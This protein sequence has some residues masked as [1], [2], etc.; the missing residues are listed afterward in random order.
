MLVVCSKALIVEEKWQHE[1]RRFDEDF[2]PLDGPA[3]R[4]CLK[5]TDLDGEWPDRY[6]RAIVPFSLFNEEFLLGDGE[7]PRRVKGLLELSPPP[8]FD[9]IIVDEAHNA[10]NPES[11][12]HR[13]LRVLCAEA[14][15]VLFLTATPIQLGSHELFYL[16]NLL[17]PDVIIDRPTFERMAEPN[18]YINMAISAAR[19]AGPGWSTTAAEALRKATDTPWGRSMLAPNPGVRSV[20]SRL[21]PVAPDRERVLLI[22]HMEELHTFSSLINRTRR[23]DIGE[24]TLRQA[25]T[26]SISF[27]SSQQTLHDEGLRLQERLLRLRYGDVP[28]TFLT[29]TIRRQLASCVHGLAPLLEDVMKRGLDA[30]DPAEGELPRDTADLV[31]SIH[32]DIAQL[33]KASRELPP[34]DPKVERLLAIA[35]EKAALPNHRLLVFSTFRHTLAYLQ[36]NLAAAGI[37]VAM[38]HGGVEDDERRLLRR[39]FARAKSDP[40]AVDVLLSSEIG[41]E[42]LDFQFCDGLVNYDIPWNPM[43]IE[44]RIGRIDR[45]GQ[46]SQSVAIWNLVTPGTVD[47]DIYERCL[48]RIGVFARSIGGC[49]EIL[50]TIAREIRTVAED[51]TLSPAQRQARLQQLAENDIRLLQEQDELEKRQV[52]LFGVRPALRGRAR[53]MWSN[54]CGWNRARLNGL[55]AAILR[56]Y[57][58]T[59]RAFWGPTSSRHCAWR[60]MRAESY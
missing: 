37:R 10:R 52:E 27:T 19:K 28:V 35:R 38:V 4:H 29:S 21:Q 20:L 17:R 2:V 44:Q 40:D 46:R 9:L 13:G 36:S 30:L 31:V 12:L 3:L 43:R 48:P 41:S 39:R 34:E 51:T 23:R 58:L 60:E 18:P 15:T 16:L 54:R 5:Q 14:E 49:E 7:G 53:R 11:W 6:A 42:G 25:H 45:Y 26:E 24:F 50:G 57:S 55:S 22:R 56:A 59:E 33:L 8:A 1:M 47:F 32:S